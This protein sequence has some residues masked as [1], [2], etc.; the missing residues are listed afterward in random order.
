MPIRAIKGKKGVRYQVYLRYKD[1]LGITST[2]YK[3]GFETKSEA[4]FYEATKLNEIKEYGTIY[5]D[6]TITVDE[7]YHEYMD[8]IGTKQYRPATIRN[9]KGTYR[10]WIKPYIKNRRINTLDY[11]DLQKFINNQKT[12]AKAFNAKK[13][14]NILFKYAIRCHYI[15]ENP[16]QYVNLDAFD[17]KRTKE[18]YLPTHEEFDL[19]VDDILNQSLNNDYRYFFLEA[20]VIC[21]MLGYYQGL[22]I[23]EAMGMLR[24]DIDLENNVIHVRH[25]T[26]YYDL[27]TRD[28]YI[29]DQLK[30]YSSKAD[31]P[32]APPLK[33]Y[34]EKWFERNPYDYVVC[35]IEGN[36]VN[37]NTINDNLYQACKRLGIPRIHFHSLRHAFT[38]NLV[39]N[40]TN[41]KIVQRLTRHGNISTTLNIY[42]HVNVDDLQDAISLTFD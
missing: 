3:G 7:L 10:N 19:I 6:C 29:V 22:R 20:C 30:N 18:D 34:L 31:L 40:G 27:K 35:D 8:K 21:L 9:Y 15:K 28:F 36:L 41:P 17:K 4:K 2:H 42:T 39:M 16:L 24:E 38:T 26:E 12:Y 11:R 14:L 33:V 1:P 23:S 25:R 37:P 32:I 5:D 13:L